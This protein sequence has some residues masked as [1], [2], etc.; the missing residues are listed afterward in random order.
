M[1]FSLSFRFFLSLPLR[2]NSHV[3]RGTWHVARPRPTSHVA[4]RTLHVARGVWYVA[5]CTACFAL[6]VY[7]ARRL[8]CRTSH[9]ARQS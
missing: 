6:H 2:R 7:V 1:S 8:A 5:R 3:A 4:S 9:V